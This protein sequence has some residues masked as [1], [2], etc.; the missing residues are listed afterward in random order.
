MTIQHVT[1]MFNKKV[2]DLQTFYLKESST[3]PDKACNVFLNL[4][5]L[6]E[7]PVNK[8]VQVFKHI[9][10][11]FDIRVEGDVSR[12]SIGRIAKEGR[13]TLK[14]QFIDTLTNAKGKSNLF[15]CL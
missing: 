9:T 3:I 2:N 7:I 10:G 12:C 8:V 14:L 5:A 11:V 6:D 4:V 13:N 1:C 15:I